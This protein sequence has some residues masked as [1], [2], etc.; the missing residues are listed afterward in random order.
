[1]GP[2]HKGRDY[3]VP[4]S[5]ACDSVICTLTFAIEV[6]GHEYQG[7]DSKDWAIRRR[8]A[9][10]GLGESPESSPII[11]TVMRISRL[12]WTGTMP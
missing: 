5:I 9:S 11:F 2:L 6:D 12:S 1:M 4:C 10:I 3:D 7:S 8:M